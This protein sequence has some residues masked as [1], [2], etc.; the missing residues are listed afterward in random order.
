MKPL[1]VNERMTS[2]TEF[3]ALQRPSQ[4]S[5]NSSCEPGYG[6][7]DHESALWQVRLQTVRHAILDADGLPAIQQALTQYLR[8]S[9]ETTMLAWY[10]PAGHQIGQCERIDGLL[11]PTDGLSPALREHFLRAAVECTL[12]KEI[13]SF[14]I[15]STLRLFSMPV[16]PYTGHSLLLVAELAPESEACARGVMKSLLLLSSFIGEWATQKASLR[17]AENARTVA[18]L[19]ELVAHVQSAGDAN[20]ACQ[21]LVDSL[22]NYLNADQV[23]AGL[24]RRGSSDVRVSAISGGEIVDPFASET[25]L[26][27]CA[28]QESLIR[29]AC[30]VWPVMDAENRHALLSHQQLVESGVG[31]T[32]ISVPLQTETGNP[33]G[34]LLVLLRSDGSESDRQAHAREIERFL[35]A[36]AGAFA[37]CLCLLQKLADSRLLQLI[38]NVRKVFTSS[39]LQLAAWILA[40]FS[41][42]LMVPVTYRISCAVELQPVQRN[43]VA[44]PFEGTLQKCLVEPG[45]IVVK[46]QIL[47]QIDGREIRWELAEVQANLNKATKERNTQLSKKEFG[48]AAISGHEMQRLEQRAALL[49]HRNVSLEIR[50]PADGVVV[51]GDHRE[52][53]GVPLEMGKTLFEI[54]PLSGMV[55]EICIPEE[56]IRHVALGMKVEIQLE[57][58]PEDRV[59]A[60]IRSIHPRAEL[61]DAKNVFV[62]K[63]DIPNPIGL[64]RPGMRGDAQIQTERHALGWN[65]FH[66]PAAWLLG[67]LGW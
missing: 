39:R 64:L 8:H 25:R 52:A 6:A 42:V 3:D 7:E 46:D 63:A 37:G 30:G 14:G 40:A 28:L 4:P 45:D 43:Y 62:A 5:G 9:S 2:G 16:P 53:E 36:G 22:K 26:L 19:I 38:Q 54:A 27:E 33:A 66:K 57:A 31:K 35:R 1:L 65:L 13:C 44:A 51:S 29:A 11:C 47:A 58:I 24:C 60:T 21:R 41:V 56:D 34:S 61:R 17:N 20:A 12:R 23:V 32:V 48:D 55:V 10:S 59:E 18:A 15:S 67:W 49:A 50:S